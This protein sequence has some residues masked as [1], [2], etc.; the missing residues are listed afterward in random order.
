MLTINEIKGLSNIHDIPKSIQVNSNVILDVFIADNLSD[1]PKTATYDFD[2]YL[3]KYGINLQRPYVWNRIQQEE[4]I[5]SLLLEKPIPPLVIVEI[6]DNLVENNGPRELLVIDGKQRLMTIQRFLH[7]EFPIHINGQEFFFNGFDHNGFDKDAKM[8][9]LR[10]I[11]FLTATIYYG[12]KDPKQRY[13][14]SDDIKIILFNFYNFA[15]TPQDE[16][17]KD[18]LQGFLKPVNI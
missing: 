1:T 14:I 9:F 7:N 3:E 13:Y 18:K 10:Q 16:S 12:S 5:L 8:F 2:V 4:F 11:R 6:D 17:H 15:G